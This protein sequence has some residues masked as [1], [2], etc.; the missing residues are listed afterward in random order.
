MM[1]WTVLIIFHWSLMVLTDGTPTIRPTISPTPIDKL[2]SPFWPQPMTFE[3]TVPGSALYLNAGFN[4]ITSF[5][6][7]VCVFFCY[8][9]NPSVAREQSAPISFAIFPDFIRRNN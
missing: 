4:F 8:F 7:E 3:L 6:N 9:L 1:K 2:P 5:S